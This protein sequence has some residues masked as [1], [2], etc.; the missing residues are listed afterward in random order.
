MTRIFH[1]NT[2]ILLAVSERLCKEYEQQKRQYD[3]ETGALHKAMQQAS[4]WYKQNRQLKRQSLVLTQRILES[5]PDALA[6]DLC[7]S[8]EVDANEIDDAEELRQTI[9][10]WYHIKFIGIIIN[11]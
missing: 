1:D 11:I 10:G 6:D 2:V 7:L 4:Q 3:V 8:D 5:R 9:T